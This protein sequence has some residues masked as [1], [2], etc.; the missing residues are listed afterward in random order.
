MYNFY[1]AYIEQS[2]NHIARSSAAPTISSYEKFLPEACYIPAHVQMLRYLLSHIL[3]CRAI[4][5]CIDWIFNDIA[6]GELRNK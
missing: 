2:K 1:N 5:W 4:F 3:H 6:A